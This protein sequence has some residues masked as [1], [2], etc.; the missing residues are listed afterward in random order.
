VELA[1]R[2]MRAWDLDGVVDP[3]AADLGELVVRSGLAQLP[4]TP[5]LLILLANFLMVR[6]VHAWLII[7]ALL[8]PIYGQH[9]TVP[10]HQRPTARS[11]IKAVLVLLANY[12][13]DTP[14]FIFLHFERAAE[15]RRDQIRTSH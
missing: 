10:A 4:G 14:N 6:H 2:V 3:A 11:T 13:P 15:S 5:M 12:R 1:A 8:R 9:T 7:A